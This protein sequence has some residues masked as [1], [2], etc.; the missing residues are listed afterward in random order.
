MRVNIIIPTYKR[1][2]SLQKT[3]RSIK[4]SN[5]KD[6]RTIII[7]DGFEDARFEQ[8][9]DEQTEV[10]QNPKRMGWIYS[11]NQTLKRLCEFPLSHP[12]EVGYF[13]GAD[14]IFFY[15]DCISKL[16]EAMKEIFPAGDGLV[17]AKQHLILSKGRIK[18]KKCGGAFALM[19]RKFVDRFPNKEAFC[20]EYFHGSADREIRNY[21]VRAGVYHFCQDAVL[22]HD[23]SAKDETRR[24]RKAAQPKDHE[25]RRE[26]WAKGLVWGES[27]ERV[28]KDG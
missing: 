26:R 6:I 1:F 15:P 23:R 28:R 9:K 19:G 7:M 4:D 13:Y 3:M 8:F 22:L 12:L 24:L 2:K 20:P 25:V 16:V 5:Y 10:R 14:D 17:S 18:P 21:A 27:L 11:M